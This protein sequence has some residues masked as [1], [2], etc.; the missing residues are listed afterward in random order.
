MLVPCKMDK[1]EFVHTVEKMQGIY[2]RAVYSFS[3]ERNSLSEQRKTLLANLKQYANLTE[4]GT[5]KGWSSNE[6]VCRLVAKLPLSGLHVCV[7]IKFCDKTDTGEMRVCCDSTMALNSIMEL[8]KHA[9][10]TK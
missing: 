6:E 7:Q 8:L 4:V 9:V 3:L 10:S 1:D 2:Q 5:K